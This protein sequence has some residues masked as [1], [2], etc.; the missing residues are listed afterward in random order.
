MTKINRKNACERIGELLQNYEVKF[1]MT[2]S[3]MDMWYE[4]TEIEFDTLVETIL[5]SCTKELRHYLDR[6]TEK[7]NIAWLDHS[8]GGRIGTYETVFAFVKFI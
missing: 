8:P 7:Y 4:M 2:G 6:Y 5:N 1:K 3:T